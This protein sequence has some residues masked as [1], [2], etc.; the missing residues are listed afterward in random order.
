M[1]AFDKP[2]TE[3]LFCDLEYLVGSVEHTDLEALS[4]EGAE[5]LVASLHKLETIFATVLARVYEAV[6]NLA[7]GSEADI[8]K[9]SDILIC[10]SKEITEMLHGSDSVRSI[11]GSS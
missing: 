9:F 10:L 5:H 3:E 8:R 7:S 6:G 2:P 4:I 1:R 11:E